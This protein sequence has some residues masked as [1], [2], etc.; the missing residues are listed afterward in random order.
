MNGSIN[1][2]HSII[3]LDMHSTPARNR[4]EALFNPMKNCFEGF[5][6]PME[7]R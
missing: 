2:Y 4:F 3:Q 7:F 5:K 6:K 1:Y